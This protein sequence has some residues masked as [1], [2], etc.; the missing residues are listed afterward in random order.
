MPQVDPKTQIRVPVKPVPRV[1]ARPSATAQKQVATA[2]T[3]VLRPG[4]R[5]MDFDNTRQ[6]DYRVRFIVPDIAG[7][8][9]SEIIVERKGKCGW[10]ETSFDGSRAPRTDDRH[11]KCR[12][13]FAK[14][15]AAVAALANAAPASRHFYELRVDKYDRAKEGYAQFISQP[16]MVVVRGPGSRVTRHRLDVLANAAAAPAAAKVDSDGD[17]FSPYSAGGT[18]CD[19]NDASR[20]PGN[21]EIPNQADE[22]C[23]PRTIGTLDRDGDGFIDWTISNPAFG[24][25]SSPMKGRDCN[26]SDPEIRPTKP[27]DFTDGIDNNCDGAVDHYP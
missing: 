13:D 14:Y 10:T 3:N 5:I 12:I 25:R 9:A 20:Y 15:S 23:D 22:D 19:D 4:I 18:D 17:G 21:T 16:V 1:Q 8:P 11:A 26:D 24:N 6:G 7:Q 27:E 2:N